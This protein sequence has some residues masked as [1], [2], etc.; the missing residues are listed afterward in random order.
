[1]VSGTIEDEQMEVSSA[2]LNSNNQANHQTINSNAIDMMEGNGED[3]VVKSQV[4]IL[5]A[6]AQ[7]GKLIDRRVRELSVHSEV[8]PINTPVSK[9]HLSGAK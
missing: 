5:D 4:L 7:Y 2:Q 6:G 3:G 1:M 9:I 8:L